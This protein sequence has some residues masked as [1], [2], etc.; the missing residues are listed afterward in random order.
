MRM[1]IFRV[2]DSVVLS[3][4]CGAETSATQPSAATAAAAERTSPNSNSLRRRRIKFRRRSNQLLVSFL[5]RNCATF[6][7]FR[8]EILAL[9]LLV[10]P[11][12]GRGPV[13]SRGF[14][15]FCPSASALRSRCCPSLRESLW[16][17]AG[18]PRG[19]RFRG[20]EGRRAREGLEVGRLFAL[21]PLHHEELV[22]GGGERVRVSADRQERVLLRWG[23]RVQRA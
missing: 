23:T 15:A 5:A 2:R 18:S 6:D 13:P 17:F 11:R 9:V 22:L 16:A 8:C 19:L 1:F 3:D 4:L 12:R 20:F 14:F 7:H 21:P 10:L